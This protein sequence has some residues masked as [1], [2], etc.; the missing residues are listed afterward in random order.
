MAE[1]KYGKY[2]ITKPKPYVVPA[3]WSPGAS[4]SAKVPG[5]LV[6]ERATRVMYLDREV[7]EGA[8]YMECLWFRKK[9]DLSRVPQPHTHD[10]DEV[11]GFFGSDQE[12][13]FDLG[14]EVELWLGDEKHIITQSCVVVI[15]KGLK[16]C[17]LIFRRV[18]RPIF[19]FTT[20]PAA[21]YAGEEK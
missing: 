18:D 6:S 7:I 5:L 14:G 1:T 9:S 16:H 4:E 19:H 21:V 3:S 20:G 17:P 13:L 15:P 10:F 2:I 12:N 8:Y 11:M